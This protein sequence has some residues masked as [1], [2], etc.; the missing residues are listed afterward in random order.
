VGQA[1]V[2][3]LYGHVNPSG[4]LPETFPVR[5]ADNPS[6]LNFPGNEQ[7]VYAEG[8][9]VGYR[10]YD[11]KQMDVAFPFGHGLSYTTFAYADAECSARHVKYS[12]NERGSGQRRGGS[13]PL[14]EREGG[15]T[16]GE[17]TESVRVS[18]EVTNTGRRAGKEVVQLYVTPPAGPVARSPRELKGFVKVALEPGQ[19][20]V[21]SFDLDKRSFAYWDQGAADWVCVT[22]VHGIELGSSSRDIRATT[23]VDVHSTYRPRL[24]VDHNT[25]VEQLLA[26][27][28]TASLARRLSAMMMADQGGDDEEA[29][30]VAMREAMARESPLRSLRNFAG[31][32]GPDLDAVIG[33]LN[34]RLGNTT[35]ASKVRAYATLIPAVAR[36]VRR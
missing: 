22:G 30:T 24:V 10:Y 21:V 26:N 16:Q 35:G 32:S 2:D 12:M 29:I 18:V 9:Y 17:Q 28:R 33:F 15:S 7:V 11:A 6:Y 20:T 8:V 1:A 13:A 31:L 25:R 5:L 19:S 34:A 14:G 4:K 3:L 36:L 27:P 23:Q